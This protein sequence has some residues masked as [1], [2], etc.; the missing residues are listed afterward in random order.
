MPVLLGLWKGAL[1]GAGLGLAAQ[2]AGLSGGAPAYL[3]HGFI[4][5][6]V[7]AVAGKPPWRQ[8]SMLRESVTP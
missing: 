6:L 3:L 4:G 7:G 5:A 2:L 1:L 8:V